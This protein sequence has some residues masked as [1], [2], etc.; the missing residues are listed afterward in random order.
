MPA[1]PAMKPFSPSDLAPEYRALFLTLEARPGI[2]SQR[3]RQASLI[4]AGRNRYEDVAAAFGNDL[5]WFAIGLIHTM[6]SS[7]RWDTHLHNGDPLRARTVQVPRGRPTRGEPPFTWE[8]SALDALQYDGWHKV[9]DWSLPGLLYQLEAF[10]G[11]GYRSRRIRT[12]YLWS[13][14]QHYTTGKFVRDGVFD[15][16]ARSA[17]VGA[18][19]LLQELIARGLATFPETSASQEVRS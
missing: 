13:G 6:E 18:A 2:V 19:V 14:C 4:A 3:D 9:R 1:S 15:P 7:G 5:P 17:Q 16:R 8:A 10:N 12:P 11:W